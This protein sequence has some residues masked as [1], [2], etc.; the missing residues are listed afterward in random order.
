MDGFTLLEVLVVLLVVSLIS[1]L[2][3]QG[4]SMVLAVRYRF[5][6]QL[7]F[8]QTGVLQSYWFRQVCMGL[9]P[10]QPGRGGVF[11]GTHQQIHGLT[12]S[13]LQ[14]ESGMTK[15]VD[16]KL[17]QNA[18]D[19][20]LSYRQGDGRFLELARWPA[21]QGGF[22]YLDGD[23]R[24]YEQWPPPVLENVTQLPA[25]VMLKVDRGRGP[26]AWF[27]AITARRQPRPL[28]MDALL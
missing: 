10:D 11:L 21:S 5:V 2:L 22:Y 12:L 24:W 7:N 14:G 23:G 8:Q 17:E 1:T 19:M 26:L 27:A 20:V 4:I 16:L 15:Q 9:T 13:P 25:A 28:V 3:V 18:A 6:D